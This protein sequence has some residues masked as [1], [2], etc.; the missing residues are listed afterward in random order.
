MNAEGG[1]RRFG[2]PL[3]ATASLKRIHVRNEASLML[4][5]AGQDP[6]RARHAA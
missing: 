5:Q 1:G 4:A 6:T 3:W 2:L